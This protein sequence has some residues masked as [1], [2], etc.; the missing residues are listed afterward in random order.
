[1]FPFDKIRRNFLTE[2]S[3]KR[4]TFTLKY[5]MSDITLILDENNVL[6]LKEQEEEEDPAAAAVLLLL[7][8]MTT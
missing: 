2:T 1:M 4:L 7:L 5:C 8:T 6:R 3:E